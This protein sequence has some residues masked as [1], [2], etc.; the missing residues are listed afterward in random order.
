VTKEAA[1]M[2]LTDD[3]FST[4]VKAVELGRGLYDNLTKYIRFQMGCLFGFI[5]S[6]LGASIFDIAGGVPFL[7]LQTLWINFTTLL[8]QAIGLGYGKPAAGLM[9]RKPRQPDE[10]ILNRGRFAWL[11]S[12]GLVMGAGTLGVLSWAEHAHTQE[13]AHTMG[14]VTFSLY[15]LFFSIATR[16]ERQTVFSLDTF[17]D[18][19]FVIATGVSIVTLLLTT[20][21]GPLEAFLK[22]PPL[23]VRQWLICLA[24]SLSIVVVTEIR[25]AVRRSS[26]A[27]TQNHPG[28]GDETP[29]PLAQDLDTGLNRA[30]PDSGHASQPAAQDR[31]TTEKV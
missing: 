17:S 12:A 29:E 20:V 23:D 5:V 9:E 8:F 2:V 15:A 25:K 13:V 31:A 27:N 1:V 28:K 22:T 14:V 30:G 16:D 21:F 10:P 7:P 19:K 26:A 11:V 4:I 6:F 18:A 3:N 24:V